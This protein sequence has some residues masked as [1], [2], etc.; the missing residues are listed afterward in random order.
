[1]ISH[2]LETWINATIFKPWQQSFDVK[3]SLIGKGEVGYT[4]HDDSIDLSKK[5]TQLMVSPKSLFLLN[6]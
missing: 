4:I 5:Q 2:V 6:T 3:M 1:M